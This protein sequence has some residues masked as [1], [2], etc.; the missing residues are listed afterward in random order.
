MRFQELTNP[1]IATE[2]DFWAEKESGR[3]FKHPISMLS[4]FFMSIQRSVFP[5]VCVS[6]CSRN[7]AAERSGAAPFI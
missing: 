2:F 4:H 5:I 1:P 7:V 6:S 3:M